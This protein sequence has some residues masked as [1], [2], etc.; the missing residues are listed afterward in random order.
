MTEQFQLYEWGHCLGKLHHC[1]ELTSGS[2]DA[3]DYPT[4][5][6]F[7]CS[8]SAVKGNNGTNRILNHDTAAQTVAESPLCFTVGWGRLSWLFSKHKPFL[9]LGTAWSTTCDHIT[10]AFP[11]VWCPS[12]MVV[13]PERYFQKS[14]V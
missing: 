12:F 13:T 6:V 11:V 3:P 2:W 7:P 5:H 4:C 10:H 1:S 14:D 8:N 9:M